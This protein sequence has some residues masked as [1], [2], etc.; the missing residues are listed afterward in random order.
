MLPLSDS[1]TK[2]TLPPYHEFAVA[3]FQGV[4][5]GMNPRERW[6]APVTE[7]QQEYPTV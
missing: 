7:I 6:G 1:P 4:V 2:N 5:C 3:L